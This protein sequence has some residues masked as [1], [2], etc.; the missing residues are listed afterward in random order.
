VPPSLHDQRLRDQPVGYY[1]DVMTRGF[2]V[3][4]SYAALVPPADRWAI[5]AYIRALQLSQQAPL[6]ELPP[7]DQQALRAVP[8][9]A[10]P[11]GAAPE[12]APAGTPAPDAA[13]TPAG[14]DA[15]G[16]PTPGA[17]H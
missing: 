5:A 16:A 12:P 4:P 8:T 14:P 10:P 2:G 15:A 11:P 6:A 3:M 13:A 9:P 1:F 17:S 7:T